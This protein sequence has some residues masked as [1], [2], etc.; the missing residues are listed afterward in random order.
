MR[1]SGS[2]NPVRSVFLNPDFTDEDIDKES[3][4]FFDRGTASAEAESA[5]GTAYGALAV[6][7]DGIMFGEGIGGIG[8]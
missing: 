8:A 4:G 2:S 6:G 7:S 3:A 5:R 1:R